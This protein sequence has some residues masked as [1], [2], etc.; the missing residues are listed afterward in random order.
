LRITFLLSINFSFDI[1]SCFYYT[2]KVIGNRAAGREFN[3][4][5]SS[6]REWRKNEQRL[7]CDLKSIFNRTLHTV[8]NSLLLFHFLK[9]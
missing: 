8:T 3:V 2:L 1:I 4:A 5:E 9:F 6:I 7:R